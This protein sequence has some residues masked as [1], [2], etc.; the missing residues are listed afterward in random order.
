MANETITGTLFVTD[1]IG[2]GI[3]EPNEPNAQ[4]HILSSTVAP[5]QAF[6]ESS[7][8]LLKLS[9][10]GSGASM[11]TANAF[12]LSIQTDGSSR[13]SI[14]STGSVNMTGALTVQNTLTV[15]GNTTIGTS[16]TSATLEVKGAV[17]A[18]SLQST[19]ATLETLTVNGNM[20]IGTTSPGDK[21]EIVTTG[22]GLT[23]R[24]TEKS[25]VSLNLRNKNGFWH[26][27]GPRSYEANNNLSIFWNNN[28][29]WLGPY[30]IITDNGN[31][32]IG[33]PSPDSPLEIRSTQD[34]ILK[35][36]Q[37]EPGHPWNYIEWW[38]SSSRLWWSGMTP[39]NIFAI[40]TDLGGGQI[41]NLTTSGQVGIG[42]QEPRTP[43]HVL[44][45]I[46]TGADFNSAGAITFY[47]PDGFAWFHIDNGPAGGRPIGR[48]RI[49]HGGNPGDNEIISI[50]QNTNVGIGTVNPQAKLHLSSVEPHAR[51]ET[52][53][54]RAVVQFVKAGQLKW[55]FGV[56]TQAGNEDF[57][58]G[59]FI[60]YR[61]IISRGTGNVSITGTLR[62]GCSKELKENIADL[63]S[64]EAV[65]TLTDL[66]PIKYSYKADIAKEQHLGFIAED[67]PDL[68]ASPDRKW[69]SAMDIVAVLTKVVQAQQTTISTLTEK[70]ESLERQSQLWQANRD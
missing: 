58:F 46:S 7:G 5:S 32:G 50:L 62:Q 33:T 47:P 8:A 36:R 10:D 68:V 41:L 4:L 43:L 12:P 13:I 44:G 35:L 6:L 57:W 19:S 17:K 49:S 42:I 23:V 21:L 25:S 48:L 40:G 11:G 54:D 67:V 16:T 14:N 37:N 18:A 70:V 53:G 9:V 39:G 38:N 3:N 29:Q 66:N 45:R 61:M 64:Q 26:I 60:A 2:I 63:S 27:S 1:K 55:D 69:L 52:T 51:I 65:K 34:S 28:S 24:E 59:D 56:G 20:G 22:N 15:T 30:L 31:V